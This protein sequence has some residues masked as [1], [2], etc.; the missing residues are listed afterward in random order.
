MDK[1]YKSP[2][3]PGLDVNLRDYIIE[4]ICLNVDKRLGPRFWRNN[5]YWSNKY[6]R[7]I[8][9]FS[10]LKNIFTLPIEDPFVQ[11]ILIEVIKKTNIK[12][13][14]AKATIQKILSN[15][16]K[17]YKQE[18]I[19]RSEVVII[20]TKEVD[21]SKNAKFIEGRK[22]NKISSIRQIENG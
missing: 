3:T 7:E 15:F 20:E 4:L 22:K 21:N 6:K 10:N 5:L 16:N 19:K 12:S 11:R 1:I 18:T 8:K 17:L 13:L 2:T 14:S 9:G